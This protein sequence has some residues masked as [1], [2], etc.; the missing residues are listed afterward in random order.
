MAI[1][2][3]KTWKSLLPLS[4]LVGCMESTGPHTGPKP[5]PTYTRDFSPLASG[6]TWSYSYHEKSHYRNGD[7]D[8][9]EG[10]V[11]FEA[12]GKEGGMWL[13]SYHVNLTKYAYSYNY[14][15]GGYDTVASVVRKDSGFVCQTISD[16]VACG[17]YAEPLGLFLGPVA[18]HH[19]FPDSMVNT[20]QVEGKPVPVSGIPICYA[21][22][23]NGPN[24]GSHLYLD[25]VGTIYSEYDH[26]GNGTGYTAMAYLD[27]FN[28]RT[29]DS[30][31][32]VD[33]AT[34]FGCPP[35]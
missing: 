12:A 32:L 4:F 16:S 18:D 3:W 1:R 9:T 30:R 24:L 19:V 23:F 21:F 5:V 35:R 34:G 28:G 15:K 11:R 17:G 7:A 10:T 8:S 33:T 6:N 22:D 25:G 27:S 20:L 29:I 14:V 31:G 13:L 2:K 26:N